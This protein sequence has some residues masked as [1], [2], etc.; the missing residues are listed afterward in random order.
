MIPRISNGWRIDRT[1]TCGGGSVHFKDR[2]IAAPLDARSPELHIGYPQSGDQNEGI[3]ERA[4][5]PKKQ[6][7]EHIGE[8]AE[9]RRHALNGRGG[10][11]SENRQNEGSRGDRPGPQGGQ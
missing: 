5:K 8:M 2:S 9:A 3:D 4:G 1:V 7:F 10:N 11:E 6:K